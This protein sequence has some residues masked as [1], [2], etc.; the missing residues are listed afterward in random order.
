MWQHRTT[1]ITK[2]EIEQNL[3][4]FFKDYVHN[5]FEIEPVTVTIQES[6]PNKDKLQLMLDMINKNKREEKKQQQYSDFFESFY[7]WLR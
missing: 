2:E 1:H 4:T 5:I 6:C 3:R 7:E